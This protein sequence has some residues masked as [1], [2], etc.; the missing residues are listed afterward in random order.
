MKR[1]FGTYLA[2]CDGKRRVQAQDLVHYR[3]EVV[4]AGT[5]GELLPRRVRGW[6]LFLE[7]LAEPHLLLL[8]PTELYKSPLNRGQQPSREY[9]PEIDDVL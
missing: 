1:A 6:E 2:T 7:F 4:E 3:V 8:M 5:I 9:M